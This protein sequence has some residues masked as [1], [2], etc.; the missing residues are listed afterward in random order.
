[1]AGKKLKG[2]E[3][4]QEP[5]ENLDDRPQ[6]SEVEVLWFG[7]QE[8]WRFWVSLLHSIMTVGP[9]FRASDP[10]SLRGWVVKGVRCGRGT[11]WVLSLRAVYLE[12]GR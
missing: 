1:M 10:A 2:E 11:W 12:E 8:R 9:I 6:S 5:K 4:C 7:G 3:R